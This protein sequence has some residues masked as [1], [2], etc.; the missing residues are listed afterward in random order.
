MFHPQAANSAHPQ[1][2]PALPVWPVGTQ[3]GWLWRSGLGDW[4]FWTGALHG[5]L[6]GGPLFGLGLGCG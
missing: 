6:G 1:P 3:S 2:F 4:Q 5:A